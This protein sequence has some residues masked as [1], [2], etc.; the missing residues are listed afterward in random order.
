V[1]PAECGVPCYSRRG[2]GD[3]RRGHGLGGDC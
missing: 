1:S 2:A 3:G